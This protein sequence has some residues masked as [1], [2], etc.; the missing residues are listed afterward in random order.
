[1]AEILV[2]SL[3]LTPIIDQLTPRYIQNIDMPSVSIRS[4]SMAPAAVAQLIGTVTTKTM[5]P[6]PMTICVTIRSQQLTDE[7]LGRRA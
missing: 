3:Q 1:M 5:N 2:F 6:E 4:S 7:R